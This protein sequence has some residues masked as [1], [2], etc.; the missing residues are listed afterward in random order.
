MM[1]GR[2]RFSLPIGMPPCGWGLVVLALLLVSCATSPTGR[3][4]LKIVSEDAAIAA[5]KQAYTKMLQPYAQ[6]GKTDGNPQLR[7]R[8]RRIT[9]RLIAQAVALTEDQALSP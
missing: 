6:Q 8:I 9:G 3:R 2:T 5:S 7:D 4:Q 1:I